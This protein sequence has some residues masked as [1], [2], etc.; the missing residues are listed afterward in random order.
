MENDDFTELPGH[1]RILELDAKGRPTTRFLRLAVVI[2]LWEMAN[3]DGELDQSEFSEIVRNMDHEFHIMDE[4]VGELIEEAKYFRGRSEDLEK[5]FREI[6][7]AYNSAQREQLF[8][9]IWGI[10]KAD[11]KIEIYER[12]FTDF[13]RMKLHISPTYKAKA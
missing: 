3:A 13:L 2:L 4:D 12:A 8:E 11:G 1:A 9:L 10:A 5:I 7:L 6:L